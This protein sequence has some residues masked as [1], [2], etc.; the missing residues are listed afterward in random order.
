MWVQKLAQKLLQ[1][2]V[3]LEKIPT[4]QSDNNALLLQTNVHTQFVNYT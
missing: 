3:I 4:T 1:N 2:S